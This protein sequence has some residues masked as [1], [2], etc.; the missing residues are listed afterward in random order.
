MVPGGE[1][2]CRQ[3]R[4]ATPK[5]ASMSSPA[6]EKSLSIRE[7]PRSERPRERLVDLGAASLSTAELIAIVV[8]SGGAGRSAVQLGHAVLSEAGGAL[9]W[10]ARQPVAALTAVSGVGTARAVVI[11]A[12]LELGRRMTLES[13][14][15]GCP[16]RSPR[17]PRPAFPARACPTSTR[18]SRPCAR[19]TGSWPIASTD[20]K[21]VV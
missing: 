15:E 5:W 10:I 19:C 8:G 16:V 9:R 17:D 13:R 1:K 4:S 3:G 18:W 6:P 21:S 11:H 14:D 2:W 7:F 20:R 12:A